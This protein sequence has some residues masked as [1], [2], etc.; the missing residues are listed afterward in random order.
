VQKHSEIAHPAIR[1]VLK[2][3]DHRGCR[4]PSPRRPA[5]ANRPRLQL[6]LY[7]RP[8]A[9]LACLRGELVSKRT[10]AEQAIFV[11]QQVLREN[12][13]VQDQ[14]QSPSAASTAST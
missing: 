11:E 5:G 7:G 3:A 10:L 1:G 9:R 8:L 12:V 2:A 6:V 4:D 14:I 13:G